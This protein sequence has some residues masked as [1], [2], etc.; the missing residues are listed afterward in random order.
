[1]CVCMCVCLNRGY[2]RSAS[3]FLNYFNLCLSGNIASIK[4]FVIVQNFNI[5]HVMM[6][7]KAKYFYSVK[8]NMTNI[9]S[10]CYIYYRADSQ[11]S[12]I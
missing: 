2:F 12:T 11:P 3:G 6:D 4:L 5:F 8:Q 9:F 10:R 7:L 1:M